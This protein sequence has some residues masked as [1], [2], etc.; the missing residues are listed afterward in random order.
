MRQAVQREIMNNGMVV[1][2]PVHLHDRLHR[3]MLYRDPFSGVDYQ[4]LAAQMTED[5]ENG[6]TVTAAEVH[7]CVCQVEPMSA[8][9]SLNEM[10][11]LD[12]STERQELLADQNVENPEEI[13]SRRLLI[14]TLMA[15]L[16][17]RERR[18]ITMRYGLDGMPERTLEEVGKTFQVSKERAR[19]LEQ[20]AMRKLQCWGAKNRMALEV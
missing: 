2:I 14:E 15:Q 1:R 8:L 6:V 18:I 5:S 19:Q 3:M 17:E 16:D 7:E 11:A 4:K 9:R 12:G 13:A 10:V 20:R